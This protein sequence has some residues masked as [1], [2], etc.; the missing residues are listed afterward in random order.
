MIFAKFA[1]DDG[2]ECSETVIYQVLSTESDLFVD[3]YMEYSRGLFHQLRAGSSPFYLKYQNVKRRDKNCGTNLIARRNLLKLIDGVSMLPLTEAGLCEDTLRI[4]K[5]SSSSTSTLLKFFD[6]TS[7]LANEMLSR[8]LVDFIVSD[9]FTIPSAK[10]PTCYSLAGKKG[11]WLV[12]RVDWYVLSIAVLEDDDDSEGIQDDEQPNRRLSFFTAGKT[13]FLFFHCGD[14]LS[15]SHLTFA[16]AQVSLTS[17]K[18]MA[19]LP[20]QIQ[21]PAM[22]RISVF[23]PLLTLSNMRTRGNIH[24]RAS[25]PSRKTFC[26]CHQLTW[27]L[28]RIP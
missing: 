7:H 20:K 3:L 13:G 25:M 21:R 10:L 19:I 8:Y 27:I 14:Y 5:C 28:W 2:S 16:I 11:I 18:A 26:Q 23:V 12:M 6:R 4:V 22:R 24:C 1:Q 17:T 9:H 15:N